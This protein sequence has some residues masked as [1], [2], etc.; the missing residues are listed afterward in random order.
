MDNYPSILMA[1]VVLVFFIGLLTCAYMF[2][3]K[4]YQ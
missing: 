2:I 3:T 4:D 1:V